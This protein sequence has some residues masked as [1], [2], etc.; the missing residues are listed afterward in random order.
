[1]F[2]RSVSCLLLF[3]VL[4]ALTGENKKNKT[5]KRN[6]NK[7]KKTSSIVNCTVATTST[8][9]QRTKYFRKTTLQLCFEACVFVFAHLQRNRNAEAF[10]Q[11]P[12]PIFF[13]LDF[14][15][16]GPELTFLF[17]VE[18]SFSVP[19]VCFSLFFSDRKAVTA[20]F[21]KLLRQSVCCL[22]YE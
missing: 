9:K 7:I 11:T 15:P 6:K 18:P 20:S 1:M 13:P 19:L 3:L 22:F 4:K 2:T 8:K 12:H 21:R 16:R 10:R 5:K 14:F 17:T